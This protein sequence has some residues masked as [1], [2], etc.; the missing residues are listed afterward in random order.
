MALLLVSA[1]A[2]YHLI[3]KSV[4][5]APAVKAACRPLNLLLGMTL[6]PTAFGGTSATL[7]IS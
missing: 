6:L 7:P 1:I 2:L 4:P 3:L 5:V